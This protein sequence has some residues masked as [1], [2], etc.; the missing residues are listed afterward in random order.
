MGTSSRTW[1]EISGSALRRNLQTFAD[2]V[3]PS[4]Q[5]MAVLKANA[6]GH[7]VGEVWQAIRSMNLWGLGVAY[8]DEALALRR[9]TTK[10]ILVL[11]YW[12]PQLLGRLVRAGIE[13]S[14]WD[15]PTLS[16][17]LSRRK[18]K[19]RPKYHLKFDTGTSRIGFLDSQ[20]RQVMRQ[21]RGSKQVR[22]LGVFSH[23]ANS[24]E[25]PIRRTQLQILRFATLIKHVPRKLGIEFH[26]ACTAASLRYQKAH[27]DLIRLGLGLYGLWPSPAIQE[28]SRAHLPEIRLHP[29]LAWYSRLSQVKV[30]PAGRSIGYGSTVKVHR[31]TRIGIVPVGYADGY[32]RRASN[33][34]WMM[35]RGRP[36]PVVGR[37]SMNLT[38]VNLERQP[39]ARPGDRTTMIGPGAEA[40]RLA[41]AMSMLN[42]EFVSRIHPSIERRLG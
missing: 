33:T 32:D 28:W 5:I 6:Y 14:V 19:H 4:V 7:G 22:P 26:L 31:P 37:V 21:F 8:D 13:L 38:A 18:Q 36:A 34:A 10:R 2:H 3:G 29:A 24:E 17:V 30:I 35:V 23:L 25:R 39:R 27:F 9:L 42:Y 15:Q 12:S 20:V 1:I 40:D 11:S 16:L 41:S